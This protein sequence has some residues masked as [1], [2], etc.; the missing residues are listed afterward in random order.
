MPLRSFVF[1]RLFVRYFFPCLYSLV[2]FVRSLLVICHFAL[3]VFVRMLCLFLS[4]LSVLSV[5]LCVSKC[6]SRYMF[7]YFSPS[8]GLQIYVCEACASLLTN[9]KQQTTL[10]RLFYS[11]LSQIQHIEVSPVWEVW[12]FISLL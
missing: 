5:L 12:R 3:L 8:S 11:I 7:V 1:V 6:G 10:S 9:K 2:L 4:F